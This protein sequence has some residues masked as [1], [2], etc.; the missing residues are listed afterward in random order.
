[1]LFRSDDHAQTW[2][3]PA[4][5][6]APD[7]VVQSAWLEHGPFAFWLIDALRPRRY[8]E[9]GTHNG[10]SYFCVCQ[11]VQR[12]DLGTACY[13][14]DSWEGDDHA[15]FYGEEV[16]ASVRRVNEAKYRG[17]S[18][19][20]RGFFSEALP[21]FPDA[22]IDLLHIDGRHGYEDVLEDF[23]NW[24]PKL[25]ERGVVLFHD[26]NVRE[27]GFGVWRL[28]HELKDRHPAFEF[29]HGHGLGVLALGSE[30]P[31]ALKPLL[32]ANEDTAAA[33][34]HSYA[35]L[36][37][38]ISLQLEAEAARVET[39]YAQQSVHDLGNH[40]RHLEGELARKEADLSAIR[41]AAEA[42]QREIA[43]AEAQHARLAAAVA[44]HERDAA[45]TAAVRDAIAGHVVTLQAT[46]RQ[47]DSRL[48]A[49]DAEAVLVRGLRQE[50]DQLRQ[51]LDAIL[52][53]TF[54]RRTDPWRR[55][56]AARPGLRR[57]LMGGAK[58]LWWTL[59][60]Q[61]PRRLKARRA[62]REAVQAA[63]SPPSPKQRFTAD[64]RADL[65]AFLASDAR[66]NFPVVE[67]PDV[68]VVIVLWNAAHF[69]L[70]CLRAL[71]AAQGPSL[72]IILVDNRSTDQTAALLER[73]E[74]A[75]ILRSPENL[76][77]LLG[78]NRGAAEAR[79]RSI[80]LL[81]SDAFPR[82]DALATALATLDGAL[83]IGAVGARL[84]LPSGQLQEAGSIV[85]SDG[86]ALGYAREAAPDA[87]EA[88]FRRDVDYCS[89]A[90]LLT[91]RTL[92]ETLG[93]L[94]EAFAPAY[95]EETDYCLRLQEA[96]YRVVY[97]PAAVVDHFE[98]GSEDKKGDSTAAMQRN[99]S[100]F[101]SR[102]AE[103]LRRA[104]LPPAEE[105]VLQA[106]SA[107]AFPRPR[108]LMIDNAVPL[109]T[110][111]AGYPRARELL[112]AAVRQGWAVT[113]FALH[114]LGEVDWEAAYNELP[115]EIEIV[116]PETPQELIGFMR[117]R[118]GFYDVVL[119][120]RPENMVLIR[121]YLAD[122]PDLFTGARVIY[123]SEALAATRT[124]ARARHDGKPYSEAEA[125][126]LITEELALARGVDAVLC[127]NEA[128]AQSFAR[129]GA[130]VHVLSHAIAPAAAP[131]PWESRIG[132][133]FIGR[134][135]ERDAPNW[136][137]LAWF[138]RDVWPRIRKLLP[139]A[140][141]TV[142]GRLHPD[143][144]ALEAP[145]VRLLGAVAD[146][147]PLYDAAR[148]FVAPV[149]FAAGV[150]LKVIE[151]G[152]AGLPVVG[153]RL[154]GTQLQ[155]QAD[156]EIGVADTA[157]EFAAACVA[158]HQQQVAWTAMRDAALARVGRDYGPEAFAARVRAIL[159]PGA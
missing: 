103:V 27:R 99:Q 3:S 5:F 81:N 2:L 36:G 113:L 131:P 61:L 78:C 87:S 150:P 95:Y 97:E 8:V 60:L 142:V 83:D 153:T 73:V 128:E 71:Q 66:I 16:F 74:G 133:L 88:M 121:G 33:I 52:T 148:V 112:G 41:E 55:C 43:N 149:H 68:S 51:Q 126:A 50:R 56:L 108:L 122:H 159:A 144:A 127:V 44:E 125:E 129:C 101:L 54:W 146:L 45:R 49:L 67:D 151:A 85:W 24:R 94:D 38:A 155:W 76:G 29:D 136:V 23:E 40:V 91:P 59:S 115:R 116:S 109:G 25:S 157:E 102:H 46:L 119:V 156:V 48:L 58:L 28:W 139:Q 147:Q 57:A 12:L 118:H 77:F 86:T 124:I 84:L 120:S 15:G 10:F 69:T 13:A 80:L 152:A 21:Y 9:L 64:A 82:P 117:A 7:D 17:F 107:A 65:S 138:I 132:F 1:M 19:L 32:F 105:N 72:E 11:A 92:W 4:S 53:S 135:M 42:A 90:F 137:G 6:W 22:S 93:G 26:V 79:G 158:L 106:R 30:V 35:R 31:E 110:A 89:G 39:G 37:R 130:P 104:H 145:G 70:R 98:F 63:L 96:G 154:M 34:R 20:M 100:L 123:D 75:R 14:V 140:T 62:A 114:A 143:H 18:T 111:G 47:R 141:L 134:L